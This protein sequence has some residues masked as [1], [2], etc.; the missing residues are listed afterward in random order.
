[1]SNKAYPG[2][3]MSYVGNGEILLNYGET[4]RVVKY[5]EF[6]RQMGGILEDSSKR[7]EYLYWY[8][9]EIK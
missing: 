3:L 2:S 6:E 1:M 8:D 5:T 9:M 7:S 4:W